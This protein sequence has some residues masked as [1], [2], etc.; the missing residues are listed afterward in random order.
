MAGNEL[1]G[2]VWGA[3]LQEFLISLAEDSSTREHRICSPSMISVIMTEGE[4]KDTHF[5]KFSRLSIIGLVIAREARQVRELRYTVIF[6]PAEE[7]GYTVT[8]PALPGC[9]SEGDTI[10]EARMNIREAIEG[11][12][13][14]LQAHGE[15]IPED[16][17]TE[18]LYEK[19][20]I[21][22]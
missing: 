5:Y 13:E 10:E 9:I 16:I 20:A 19:I 1:G 3:L 12:I 15:P 8:V 21:S 2:H 14:S 17:K 22:F 18:P 6:E 11:Y 4:R 7:G